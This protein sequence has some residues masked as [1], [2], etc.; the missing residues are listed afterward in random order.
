MSESV[1][2]ETESSSGF[3]VDKDPPEVLL[4]LVLLGVVARVLLNRTL[5]LVEAGVTT[6]EGAIVLFMNLLDLAGVGG[7]RAANLR[8]LADEACLAIS[9]RCGGMAGF[10]M[11]LA[12]SAYLN[13]F[14]VSATSASAGLTQVIIVV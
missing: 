12:L 14:M 10:C 6:D 11:D 8:F 3:E 2:S 4:L 9:S 5:D 13:V 7:I 1:S